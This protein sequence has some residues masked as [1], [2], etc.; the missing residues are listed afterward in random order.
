MHLIT[1]TTPNYY[2]TTDLS[3]AA[4]P[5]AGGVLRQSVRPGLSG[6]HGQGLDTSAP[7][8]HE[9]ASDVGPQLPASLLAGPAVPE[10]E[11]SRDRI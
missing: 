5:V 7:V 10:I 6:G 9:A 8:L 1:P 11:S 2:I 3:S 4:L